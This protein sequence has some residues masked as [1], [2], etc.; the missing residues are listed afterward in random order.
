M[1]ININYAAWENSLKLT[2]SKKKNGGVWSFFLLQEF[3]IYSLEIFQ[4]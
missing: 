2:R 4:S 3:K 1:S